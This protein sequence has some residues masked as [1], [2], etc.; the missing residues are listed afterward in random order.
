MLLCRN[1]YLYHFMQKRIFALVLVLIFS[2]VGYSQNKLLKNDSVLTKHFNPIFISAYKNPHQITPCLARPYTV[3]PSK[4]ELMYWPNYPLT[5]AQIEARNRKYDQSLGQQIIGSIAESY[6]NS[7]L[8]GKKM[9]PAV[10]P[11]F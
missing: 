8:Y 5:A 10:T 2:T 7:L 4:H 6:I 9:P 11:K 3:K 1:K